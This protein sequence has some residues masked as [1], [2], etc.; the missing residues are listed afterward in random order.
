MSGRFDI[1]V[2]FE[3]I[4]NAGDFSNFTDDL[5]EYADR[6]LKEEK[7]PVII[8]DGKVYSF[9]DKFYIEEVGNNADG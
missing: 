3:W 6:C 9:G 1:I 2:N 5:K 4:G 8:M 7:E